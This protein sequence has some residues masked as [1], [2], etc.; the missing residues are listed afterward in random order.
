MFTEPHSAPLSGNIIGGLAKAPLHT[1]YFN[2]H[3]FSV[4]SL[5]G[6]VLN[7]HLFNQLYLIDDF[8][9]CCTNS[10]S[11]RWYFKVVTTVGDSFYN[12]LCLYLSLSLSVDGL[13]G[14]LG[15]QN[16]DPVDLTNEP[17]TD[18]HSLLKRLKEEGVH[19][20]RVSTSIL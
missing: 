18:V 20:N 17:H 12:F 8:D 2:E 5:L 3:L 15:K 13:S 7:L 9:L 6:S 14:T 11:G 16:F 1:G 10:L 19:R 4:A